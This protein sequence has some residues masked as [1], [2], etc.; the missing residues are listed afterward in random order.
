MNGGKHNPGSQVGVEKHGD[1][2]MESSYNIEMYTQQG[3]HQEMGEI[4]IC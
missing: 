3:L 1:T 4:L 2:I